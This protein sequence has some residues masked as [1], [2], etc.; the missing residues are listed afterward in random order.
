MRSDVS[1]PLSIR[2]QRLEIIW[3]LEPS[4]RAPHTWTSEASGFGYTKVGCGHRRCRTLDVPQW[5]EAG[6]PVRCLR[7]V[8]RVL[9]LAVPRSWLKPKPV[10]SSAVLVMPGRQLILH[11]IWPG[12]AVNTLFYAAILWLVIPGPFALRRHIRRKRGRC[13]SCGYDLR[14]ADHDAC[15]DCGAAIPS[16]LRERARVRVR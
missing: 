5:V 6:W 9:G 15:P 12:F 14:H 13:I 11:P 2:G 16:P 4:P 1:E 3:K 8:R 7:G 10:A